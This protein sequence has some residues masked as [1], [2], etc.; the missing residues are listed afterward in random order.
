MFLVVCLKNNST[1]I[2]AKTKAF[3]ATTGGDNARP[4][5]GRRCLIRSRSFCIRRS[6]FN[7]SAFEP[8]VGQSFVSVRHSSY[9][10][11][12][13]CGTIRRRNTLVAFGVPNQGSLLLRLQRLSGSGRSAAICHWVRMSSVTILRCNIL[14][15]MVHGT[16]M[17]AVLAP[18]LA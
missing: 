13:C 1:I 12:R 9:F 7:W 5:V 2:W 15:L 3:A 16:G 18:D 10:R 11:K 6:G 8:S 4:R 14:I 17:S